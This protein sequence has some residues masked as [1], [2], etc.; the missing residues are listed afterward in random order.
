MPDFR[1]CLTCGSR[2]QAGLCPCT[3]RLISKQPEPSLERF[4]YEVPGPAH[5]ARGAV[6]E[7]PAKIDLSSN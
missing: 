5:V 6:S 3:Q 7:S 2:G 1:L 4:R